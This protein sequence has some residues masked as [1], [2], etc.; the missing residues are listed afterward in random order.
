[1]SATPQE[2]FELEKTSEI[3]HE[4]LNGEIVAMAGT[5]ANHERIITNTVVH[6]GSQLLGKPCEVFASGKSLK[7]NARNYTYPDLTVTCSAEFDD[8]DNLI[9]PVVIF[10][11]LSPST[12]S[13]DRGAKFMKY[14]TIPSL[15]EYV[16]IAQDMVYIDHYTLLEQNIWQFQPYNSLEAV[17][18]LKSVNLRLPLEQ[19]YARIE[20]LTQAE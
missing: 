6:L 1:M 5:S 11:V 3:R 19:I 4:Y 15:R 13:Y 9:N 18:E 16:L 12:E 2:Y 20:F 10:E 7:I 8:Y 14:R 17:L